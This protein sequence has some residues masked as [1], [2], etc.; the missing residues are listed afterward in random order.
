MNWV[1]M[2]A[3]LPETRVFHAS[4]KAMPEIEVDDIDAV[5]FYPQLDDL[6][7]RCE[8]ASLDVETAEAELGQC[9]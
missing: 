8:V 1:A 7:W 9:G 3:R 5:R 6:A 4:A 2:P